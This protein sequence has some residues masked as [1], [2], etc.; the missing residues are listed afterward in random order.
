MA[1]Y[2]QNIILIFLISQNIILKPYAIS[3]KWSEKKVISLH[4]SS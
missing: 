4:F 1:A 2:I 3:S